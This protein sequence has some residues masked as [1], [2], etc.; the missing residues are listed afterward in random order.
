MQ[1]ISNL[2]AKNQPGWPR[3][4]SI[5]G[6]TGSIGNNALE[7]IRRH[8]KDFRVQALSGA[9]NTELLAEQAAEFRP[10]FL[11]VLNPELASDLNSRLPGDYKPTIL[12]GPEG[13]AE[14][15]GLEAA[16]MVLCAQVGAA[17]LLPAYTAVSRGKTVLLANKEALVLAGK[18]LRT[19]ARKSGAVILPVDS[20][21]NAVFQCLHP[22][23]EKNVSR[24]VLTASGGPFRTF[25]KKQLR[26]VTR[27]QAL[28]HP[29]WSM[30][31]KISVDSA[32]MMNKGLEVI[33][34]H[35]LFGLTAEEISVV[36][37]PQSIVHS[38]VEYCDGSMLAHLG[39]P[40]MKAP[41]GYCL[42]FPERMDCGV[43]SLDLARTGQL[44][45]ETPATE[46]FPCLA[47]ALNCL[48]RDESLPIILNAANEVAVEA[49]LQDKISFVRISD[50][51]QDALA[52]F[53]GPEVRT[54][55]DVFSLDREVRESLR[56]RQGL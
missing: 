43:Q 55:E 49:F 48:E 14:L 11:G 26:E 56:D 9:L 30:G 46:R 45:F 15:A 20:E 6:S 39:M 5:L 33:E 28:D 24:V 23:Q 27:E 10:S 1:Y 16:D 35:H 18:L 17:G 47:A 38:L 3:N 54:I 42:S 37:H 8:K 29:N 12:T 19:E 25:S 4:V 53:A 44:T 13:Y 50:I 52:A 34:A 31:A 22:G 36:V 21:H 7:V 2:E 32:T 40:D 51:V 41:I